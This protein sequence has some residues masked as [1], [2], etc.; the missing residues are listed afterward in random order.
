[1][2]DTGALLGQQQLLAPSLRRSIPPTAASTA[3]L[4]G[5]ADRIVSPRPRFAGGDG[6]SLE[7]RSGAIILWAMEDTELP[8]VRSFV[9][10]PWDRPID[11]ANTTLVYLARRASLCAILTVDHAASKG[12]ANSALFRPKDPSQFLLQLLARIQIEGSGQD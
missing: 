11:F 10:R 8:N 4:R 5:R 9:S 3:D 1:V 2:I 12:N 6:G 7:I